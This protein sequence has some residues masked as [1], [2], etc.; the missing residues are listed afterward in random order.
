[1]TYQTL[2][3]IV[4][5]CIGVASLGGLGVILLVLPTVGYIATHQYKLQT[6]LL[7]LKGDRINILNEVISGIKV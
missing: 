6:D 1:M 2:F 4:L 5:L 3:I 7:Y